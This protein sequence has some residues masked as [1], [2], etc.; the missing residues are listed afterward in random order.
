MN[1]FQRFVLSRTFTFLSVFV[2]FFCLFA[3]V[4]LDVNHPLYITS[5]ICGV[6]VFAM[7]QYRKKLLK[8]S[9]K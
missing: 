8:E 7:Q 6:A 5:I 3:V 4:L 9:G 2:I 1:S